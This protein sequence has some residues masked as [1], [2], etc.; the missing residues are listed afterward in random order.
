[1]RE[2]LQRISDIPRRFSG[3]PGDRLGLS[4]LPG[5]IPHLASP[6]TQITIV[7]GEL[8]LFKHAGNESG[9]RKRIGSDGCPNEPIYRQRVGGSRRASVGAER[10]KRRAAPDLDPPTGGS[11]TL[12]HVSLAAT[13]STRSRRAQPRRP[14]VGC[15]VSRSTAP[16]R[17]SR[18]DNGGPIKVCSGFTRVTTRRIAQPLKVTFDTRLHPFRLPG[19]TAR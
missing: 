7:G 19:R 10:P 2:R 9:H 18:H 5:G 15:A 17:R 8:D 1:M 4:A 14:S 6:V 16:W 11:H 12:R 13:V 3:G